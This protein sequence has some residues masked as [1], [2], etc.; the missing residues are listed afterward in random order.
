MR[1]NEDRAEAAKEVMDVY[2]E[3]VGYDPSHGF[4][5]DSITD[6][7]VD[8]MHAFG[9]EVVLN[10]IDVATRHYEYEINYES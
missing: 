5:S 8:L 3:N 1:T 4:A 9:S 6:L 10:G 7:L 2:G